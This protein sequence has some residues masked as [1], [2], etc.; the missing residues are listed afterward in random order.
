MPGAARIRDAVAARYQ[1]S[2]SY[3]EFLTSEAEIVARAVE[4]VEVEAAPALAA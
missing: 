2:P 1:Q 4:S 3:Q